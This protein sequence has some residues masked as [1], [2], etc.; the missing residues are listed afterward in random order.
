MATTN[1]NEDGRGGGAMS[2]FKKVL[3]LV[4]EQAAARCRSEGRL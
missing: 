2:G 1:R 4:K 3:R